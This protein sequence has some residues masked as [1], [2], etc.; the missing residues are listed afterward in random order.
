[1]LLK[2][3]CVAEGTSTLNLLILNLKALCFVQHMFKLCIE[4]LK[5]GQY[6]GFP[7]MCQTMASKKVCD[8]VET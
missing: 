4:K 6:Q 3:Q 5:Y 7:M 2:G 1:M 8:V